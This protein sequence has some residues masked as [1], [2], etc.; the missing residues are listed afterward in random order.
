[1]A[2]DLPVPVGI[3]FASE[4]AHNTT[5]LGECFWPDAIVRDE[6]R[7]IEGLGAISAWRAETAKK[8]AHRVEPLTIA[9]RGGKVIVTAKVSGTFPGSPIN[10][11]HIFEID[12]A[13]EP[14]EIR[15]VP[16][17]PN[18]LAA[19]GKRPFLSLADW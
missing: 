11:D 8:Y 15:T 12:G 10:L 14:G 2:I 4:N 9:E 6:G 5:A 1:M 3:Y 18:G 7:T 13:T 17:R 19:S 16:W